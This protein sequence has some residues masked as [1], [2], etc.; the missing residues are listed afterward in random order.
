[1]VQLRIRKKNNRARQYVSQ[2]CGSNWRIE[3]EPNLVEREKIRIWKI[4]GLKIRFFSILSLFFR[5]FFGISQ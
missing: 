4:Q 3:Q 2:F 1:M 5:D